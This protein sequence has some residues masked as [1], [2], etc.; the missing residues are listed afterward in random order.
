[1]FKKVQLFLLAQLKQGVTPHEISLACAVGLTGSIFP[2]IGATT[3]L[4]FVT[5]HFLRLNHP[6]VQTVNYAAAPLQLLLFPVFIKLGAW[7]CRVPS[8][9]INPEKIYREFMESPSFFFS[10]YGWAWLQAIL[11]WMLLAP[12]VMAVVYQV[13]RFVFARTASQKEY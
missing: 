1:M 3:F 9:S 10:N 7:I 8:V 11:A 12:V 13:V 5:A 6:V 4:C 2:A